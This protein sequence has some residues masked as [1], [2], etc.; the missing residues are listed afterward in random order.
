MSP[1]AHRSPKP[2]SP[3]RRTER[4]L[5]LCRKAIAH[6]I[7]SVDILWVAR[8]GFDL[9]AQV[10]NMHIDGAL[11]AFICLAR[12]P[13]KQIEAR[14]HLPRRSHQSR[15]NSELRWRKID[16]AVADRKSVV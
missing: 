10:T 13:I 11:V 3:I 15:Q 16:R 14:E 4:R 2:L 9:G 1:G 6:A 7:D 12:Y 8:V 5:L